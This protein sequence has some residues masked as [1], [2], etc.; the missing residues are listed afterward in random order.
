MPKP[1]RTLVRDNFREPYGTRGSRN[2]DR[3]RLD[4]GRLL[5]VGIVVKIG[6]YRQTKKR[7]AVLSAQLTRDRMAARYMNA[8]R[9]TPAL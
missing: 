7:P 3:R 1:V 6:G 4:A 8:M 5:A 2:I 9:D